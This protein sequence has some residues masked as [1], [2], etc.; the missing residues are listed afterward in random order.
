MTLT[1]TSA[2]VLTWTAGAILVLGF[3]YLLTGLRAG[4]VKR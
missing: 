1:L 4:G 2:D 3:V